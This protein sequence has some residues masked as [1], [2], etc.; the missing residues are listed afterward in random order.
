MGGDSEGASDLAKLSPLENLSV[1]VAVRRSPPG[2][3]V[4]FTVKV[5]R[6]TYR[7]IKAN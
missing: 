5:R 1:G 7:Q 4:P 6:D 2:A 3:W